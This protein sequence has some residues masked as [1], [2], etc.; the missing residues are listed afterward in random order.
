[1]KRLAVVS[2]SH[3]RTG[4]VTQFAERACLEGY[5]AILHLGDGASDAKALAEKTGLPVTCV[6][7]NC[8]P[9][10]NVPREIVYPCEGIRL[11]LVHGDQY[12]VRYSLT[13]LCYRAEEQGARAALFGH[14]H[15]PFCDMFGGILLLNPGALRD[16]RYA[17]LTME[18][19]RLIPVLKEL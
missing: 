7:G 14:T 8:D 13:R 6:A 9:S 17:E 19:D 1:M 12:G 11:L 2:D 3:G 5:D 4:R 18:A 15:Q 16:G 10:G